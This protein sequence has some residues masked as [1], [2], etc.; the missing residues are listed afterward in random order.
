VLGDLERRIS[1]LKKELEMCR[2]KDISPQQVHRE[3]VLKFK[4]NRLE[5]Q[6]EL[7]WKQ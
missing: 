7:Y 3:E 2:R 5:D 1:K 4:L 6:K